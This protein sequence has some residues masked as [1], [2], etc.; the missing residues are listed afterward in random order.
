MSSKVSL[1]YKQKASD[2][3]KG[4]PQN[5]L[6]STSKF[7]KIWKILFCFI[8]LLLKEKKCLRNK[9]TLGRRSETYTWS[10]DK[11]ACKYLL[12]KVSF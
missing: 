5:K 4:A 11:A 12:G 3:L 7:K 2:Q 8:F 9:Y 1:L 10:R 6:A